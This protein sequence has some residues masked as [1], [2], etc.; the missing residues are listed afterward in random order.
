[1]IPFERFR[2]ANGLEVLLHRDSSLPLVAVNLWYHVG[3]AQEASGRSGFAHLFEHLMFEGSRHAGRGF[4]T[5]L[6][7]AGATSVNGTTS[8]D[9]TNYFE[10]LPRQHLELALWLESDRMGF[11]LDE[12]TQERLE[13]QREV[14]KNERRQRYDN[15]P[16]GPSDLAMTEALFPATHPYHG[17]VIGSM[18]DLSR[19][20]LEDVRSFFQDHYAPSNATLALAGDFEP[21]QARALVEKYFGTLPTRPRPARAVVPPVTLE[22]ER[23]VEVSEP[24]KLARVA[25]GWLTPPA[26]S[27]D[28]VQLDVVALLLAGGKATRLYRSLV[29]DERVASTVSASL[30]SNGLSSMFQIEALVARDVDP[31]RTE[32]AVDAALASLAADGP[33]AAELA[34]AKRRLL[35]HVLEDLQRLDGPG[36]ES[37]RAGTLQRLNHYLGDPGRLGE[38]LSRIES[39]SADDVRRA[40]TRHLPRTA[41]VVVVTRPAAGGGKP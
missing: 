10:T 17:A 15:A 2:L 12:I 40:V 20:S 9:R 16:Y 19:A 8:W 27:P 11:L 33:A 29:V 3:P 31:G 21:A 38:Y 22:G 41:R 30:D 14:V 26:Y 28:D 36:G 39:V 18:A 32:R 13:V 24:V 37:G 5:L 23:R 7:A 4:D 25:I 35:L 34:R 1:E 6:E